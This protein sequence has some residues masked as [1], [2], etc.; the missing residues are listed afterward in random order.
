MHQLSLLHVLKSTYGDMEKEGCIHRA[1][2]LGINISQ[3]V[4]SRSSLSAYLQ[5]GELVHLHLGRKE[6]RKKIL[7]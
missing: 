1:E 4:S 3:G 7:F 2:A 6:E 5:E